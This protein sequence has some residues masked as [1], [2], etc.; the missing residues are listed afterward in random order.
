[1]DAGKRGELVGNLLVLLTSDCAFTIPEVNLPLARLACLN[2]V[3]NCPLARSLAT[4]EVAKLLG[5]D[6]FATLSP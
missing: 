2:D 6:F 3:G 4:R 1:M 5:V